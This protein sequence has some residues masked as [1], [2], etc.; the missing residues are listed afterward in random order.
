MVLG[1]VV[2]LAAQEVRPVFGFMVWVLAHAMPTDIPF[3]R[4]LLIIVARLS[5]E[6]YEEP[7]VIIMSIEGRRVVWDVGRD[8]RC[9]V[10]DREQALLGVE[11]VHRRRMNPCDSNGT[12]PGC[13]AFGDRYMIILFPMSSPIL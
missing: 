1:L 2:P 8:I 6:G 12:P 3:L 10:Q 5:E 7:S 4:R 13:N 11:G 9:V